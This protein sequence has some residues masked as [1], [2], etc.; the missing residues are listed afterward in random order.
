MKENIIDESI[1]KSNDL[2]TKFFFIGIVFIEIAFI[3]YKFLLTPNLNGATFAFT[4]LIIIAISFP[5]GLGAVLNIFKR[6]DSSFVFSFGLCLGYGLTGGIWAFLI[7]AGYPLNAYLYV[8]VIVAISSFLLF[9]KREKLKHHFSKNLY[10]NGLTEL[11]SPIAVLLFIFIILSLNWLNNT[12]PTG[13][14]CQSDSYNALMILKN[15]TYPIVTPFLDQTK[16]EL[17]SGPLFHTLTAVITELKNGLLLPEIMAITII[18]GAF[19]TMAIY[20]VASLIINNQIILF[21]TGILTLTR[22]YYSF[23]KDGN[24]PENAAFFY[25]AL[26][27]FFILSTLKNQRKLFAISAGFC[28]TFCALSHPEIFMYNI[29]V[30]ALFL[31]T[32]LIVKPK[33]WQKDYLNLIIALALTIIMVI[34]YA[35]RINH[36]QMMVNKITATTTQISSMH[37]AIATTLTESLPYWNGY[38]IPLMALGG[39]V[40]FA[41]KRKCFNIYFWTYALAVIIFIEHWRFFQIFDFPWFELKL[42]DKPSFATS[43]GYKTFLWYPENYHS[44]WYAALIVWPIATAFL[45]DFLYKIG[46]NYSLNIPSLKKHL[47]FSI[48]PMFFLVFNEIKE[49]PEY[50]NFIFDTDYLTSMWINENL[51][52]ENS[53]IYAPFDISND[54]A[55]PIHATSFWLPIISEKRTVLYR[56]YDIPGAFKFLSKK[57]KTVENEVKLFQQA[58]YSLNKPESYKV[59]KDFGVTHIFVSSALAPVFYE[60]YNNSPYVEMIHYDQEIINEQGDYNVSFLYKLK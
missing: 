35:L 20:F 30:F 13:V 19:F 51:S 41:L 29:T 56:N 49:T 10:K 43:Y 32:F 9:I 25:A 33:N 1:E 4:L 2:I 38:L 27:I 28:L 52:Y 55:K 58:A 24:L 15:K 21:F 42:L 11:L 12:V 45:I 14:D 37:D 17:Q 6:D 57:R 18:S 46:K 7:L 34:P 36:K 59:F 3:I 40:I 26:F 23:I 39:L 53:L 44:S 5:I 54:I 8:G 16:L 48:F 31:I 60:P 22:G 50:K 47:I